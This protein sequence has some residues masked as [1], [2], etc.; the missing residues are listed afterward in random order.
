[1]DKVNDMLSI[2]LKKYINQH[3]QNMIIATMLVL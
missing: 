3:V 2:T 1:M